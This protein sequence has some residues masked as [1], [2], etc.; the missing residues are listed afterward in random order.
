MNQ[1]CAAYGR[2]EVGSDRSLVDGIGQ[3]DVVADPPVRPVSATVVVPTFRRPLSLARVLE[4]LA[5]QRDPGVE[6]DVVIVDNDDPPGAE[7]VVARFS[8]PAPLRLVREARRGASHTRNRG[9]N[10]ATGDVI[11]FMDDDVV[12][13]DDW[14]RELLAP[15]IAGRADGTGGRVVLDPMVPRPRWFHPLMAWYLAEHDPASEERQLKPNEFVITASAAFRADVFRSGVSFDPRL[16]PRAGVQLVNDDVR[17]CEQFTAAGGRIRHVPASV[18]VHELPPDRLRPRYLMRRAYTQGRSDWI[19]QANTIGR[20]A[21]A[22]RQ[23]NWLGNELRARWGERLWRRPV[24]L[25]LVCDFARTAGALREIAATA[26]TGF[27]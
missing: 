20:R 24:A 26:R 7:D 12:P 16:G 6:W 8:L 9:V 18:V 4:G 3:H 23:V 10:E 19:H 27:R 5:R 15:I 13:A 25:Q 2:L 21:A 22:Q 1:C 11:V 17:V 14:L